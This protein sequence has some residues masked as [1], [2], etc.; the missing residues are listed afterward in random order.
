MPEGSVDVLVLVGVLEHVRDLAGAI[1]HLSGSL[2]PCGRLY[3]GVPDAS[4]YTEGKDAPYQE[5]S[6]EHINFFGPQ[7]L[8]NL[9]ARYGFRELGSKQGMV[10]FS[11][12]T[13]T[14]TLYA[15]FESVVGRS[16][17]PIYDSVTCRDLA[18]YVE[19][20]A[21]VDRC[22]QERIA[23]LADSNRP[24]VVWGTGSHTQRLLATSFSGLLTSEIS[25]VC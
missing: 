3:I 5:F 4:R 10:E 2:A 8:V 20:S 7:S 24:V 9:M 21:A 19:Q 13:K 15:G 6:L 12:W 22:I 14:P 25:R 18:A 11:H 23:L 1:E 17:G 16:V